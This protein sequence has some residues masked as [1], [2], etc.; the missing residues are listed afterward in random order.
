MERVYL[1]LHLFGVCLLFASLGGL[2]L[3]MM[4]GGD[5]SSNLNRKLIMISHGLALIIMLVA[6]VG[7]LT[8]TGQTVNQDW[9]H[10]KIGIWLFMGAAPAVIYRVPSAAKMLWFILPLLGG[11]A[12]YFARFK[13]G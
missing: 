3:H 1:F 11:L 10:A 9:V 7:Y 5:K 13:L 2:A 12:F 4:N 6:G 8:R